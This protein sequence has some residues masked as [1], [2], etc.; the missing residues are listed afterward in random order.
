MNCSREW[1]VV[2]LLLLPL[3]TLRA[4]DEATPPRVVS[5][6]PGVLARGKTATVTLRGFQLTRSTTLTVSAG[7]QQLKV[8]VKSAEGVGAPNGLDV[9][10]VGDTRLTAEIEVPADLPTDQL[11]LVAANADVPAA[12]RLVAVLA[13]ELL[14]S[15]AE[16]NNGFQ[17]S[18]PMTSGQWLT[19]LIDP[20][21]NIDVYQFA[22]VAGDEWELDL[23]AARGGSSLDGLL[24]LH[25][26][27]GRLIAT[28][29]DQ[30]HSRDPKLRVKLP[31]DGHYCLT[32]LD[33]S[34]TASELHFYTLHI[35]RV[36]PGQ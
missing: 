36:E 17:Q 9:K 35:R 25:T 6:S 16:P 5:I 4:A 26:Q 32:V 8:I 34:D 11:Q 30:S 1:L 12:P 3:A 33:A 29:D 28:T 14:L 22:G 13:Q 10:L 15:E 7:E 31:A 20:K 23:H 24:M 21:Q 19:G 2:A 27:S 18:Q